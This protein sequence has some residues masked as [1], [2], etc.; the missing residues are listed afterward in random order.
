MIVS[1][2]G[3]L[4]RL[5]SARDSPSLT[6]GC[7]IVESRGEY[8][9]YQTR[10]HLESMLF[11]IKF[12]F[13]PGREREQRDGSTSHEPSTLADSDGPCGSEAELCFEGFGLQVFP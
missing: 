6:D 7:P 2:S 9:Q 3:L 13:V 5:S 1:F 4:R 8:P 10:M 11:P 12:D